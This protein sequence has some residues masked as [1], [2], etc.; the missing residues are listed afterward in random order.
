[1]K[2]Q[3]LPLPKK[4]EKKLISLKIKIE[5]LDELKKELKKNELTMTEVIEWGIESFLAQVNLRRKSIK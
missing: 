4:Q 3:F 5:L 2:A 1:M